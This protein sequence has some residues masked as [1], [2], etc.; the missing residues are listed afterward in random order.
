MKRYMTFSCDQY[1]P[2]GGMGDFVG[3]FD[4]LDETVCHLQSLDCPNG[5]YVSVW[6]IGENREAWA[7]RVRVEWT[8]SGDEYIDALTKPVPFP[9]DVGQRLFTWRRL[10]PLTPQERSDANP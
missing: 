4:A 1:E 10:P 9:K 7:K 2:S 6:D 8:P 5:T 3:D